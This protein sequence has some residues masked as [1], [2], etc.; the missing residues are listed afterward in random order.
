MLLP[1]GYIW[2]LPNPDLKDWISS[3][4]RC[5]TNANTFPATNAPRTIFD[6]GRT[7][8]SKI[9]KIARGRYS[10]APVWKIS[11]AYGVIEKRVTAQSVLNTARILAAHCTVGRRALYRSRSTALLSV[12]ERLYTSRSTVLLC[13]RRGFCLGHSM[14]TGPTII[15]S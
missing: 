12:Q 11:V 1:I 4:L 8:A 15:S 6:R 14:E 3:Q 9:Q 2:L 7:Q 13:A 10:V 5:L